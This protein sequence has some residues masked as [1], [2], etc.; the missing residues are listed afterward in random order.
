M[1]FSGFI[2]KKVAHEPDNQK[3]RDSDKLFEGEA[4]LILESKPGVYIY[5]TFLLC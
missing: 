1:Y 3:F 4:P 2:I 5:L